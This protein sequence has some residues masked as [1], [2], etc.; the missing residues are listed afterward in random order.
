MT[1]EKMRHAADILALLA[2]QRIT[3]SVQGDA[4]RCHAPKGTL[5]PA[6]RAMLQEHKA[7]LLDF[8]RAQKAAS[9]VR[10]Q[11]VRTTGQESLPAPLSFA[12]QRLWFLDQ[13]QP[14]STTYNITLAVRLVGTL[15]VSVLEQSLNEVVRRH[16]SLR[17][18]FAVAEGQPVQV[19]ATL[20]PAGSAPLGGLAI[21]SLEAVPVQE[22]ERHVQQ[23]VSQEAE[24]PFNLVQ[25]P[26]MRA[27]L[28][29]L[30][31]AE[32]VLQLTIHHIIA[33]GWSINILV[34][35]LILLY[36]AYIKGQ[37]SP[38]PELPIQYADYARFQRAWLQGEV[39]Q[40][41]LAYWKALLAG[42]PALLELPLDY[43][44]P[45]VQTF[46]GATHPVSLPSPLTQ[47]LR[48]LSQRES[49]TLFMTLLA[50]FNVLLSRY[51]RQE[52]IVVGTP[53]ANRTHAETEGLIG[54]FVNMLALRTD[55]TGNPS[56]HDLLRRVRDVTQ[57]AYSHQ[58]VPFEQVVEALQPERDL[59]YTPLFQVVLTLQKISLGKVEFDNVSLHPLV[60][61]SK[62]SQFDLV[63]HLEESSTVIEGMFEYNTDL[64]E[65]ATIARM[66]DHWLTL[67]QGIVADPTQRISDLR[68]L[69]E[70][71]RQCILGDWNATEAAYPQ[72]SC[73]HELF[74]AQVERSPDAIAVVWEDLQITYRELNTR[75]NRLASHLQQLGVGPE[76][77]VCLCME[78]SLDLVVGL[79]GILKAGGAYVPLDPTY[80]KERLAF[81]VEDTQARVLLTQQHLAERIFDAAPVFRCSKVVC[82]DTLQIMTPL[83][84][85]ED[86]STKPR[87]HPEHLVYVIYTSGS[88]GRPKG[89]AV[90][91]RNLTNLVSWHCR[92]FQLLPSDRTT[93]LAGIG[94]DA[95]AWEIWPSLLAGASLHLPTEAVRM[96]PEKLRDWLVT[97]GITVTFLPTPMAEQML[98]LAWPS[99]ISLRTILTGGDRLHHAPP[100]GLPF[101]LVNN[102]GPT[103]NTV[104][105]TSGVIAPQA[106]SGSAHSSP[107][108]TIGRPIANTK[109]Y[110]L[111]PQQRLVPIGVP[112][113]LCIG[114]AGIARGYLHRPELTAERFIQDPLGPDPGARLYRT[115]DL[116]RYRS[117][118]TIEFLGRLDQ[119]V[120]IRGFRI[121]LGEIETQ[122]SQHPVI[123]EAAVLAHA[124]ASG[125]KRLVAYVV[126]HEDA[127]APGSPDLRRYLQ[128]HLPDY[129]IPSDFIALSALPLTPN[130]KLDPRALPAPHQLRQ[131]PGEA[132]VAPRDSWELEMTNLWETVLGKHP[133]GV[134][135]D[136]FALGG[137]SLLA[138]ALMTQVQTLFGQ[139]LPLTALF[140]E[141]TIEHLARLLREHALEK[142]GVPERTA[143]VTRDWSPL[144]PIQPQGT[145]HP[146]FCVHGADGTVLG[147]RALARHLGRERPFYGLQARGVD[148]AQEPLTDIPVMASLYLQ[149][150]R[151][152]QPEGPYL[153]GGW[154]IGGLVAFEMAQQLVTQGQQVALV[155]L[156]DTW[157]AIDI[158]N[159]EASSP[160][161]Q[162]FLPDDPVFLTEMIR[163]LA[164]GDLSELS[165]LQLSSEQIEGIQRTIRL[166]PDSSPEQIHRLLRLYQINRQASYQYVPHPY[167]GQVLLFACEE[168]PTSSLSSWATVVPKGLSI[169]QT[170]GSHYSML[171]EPHVK[172]LAEHLRLWLSLRI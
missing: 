137:H 128:I 52:D 160:E 32:Y 19:I 76:T 118:G 36:Q 123:R 134:Q 5:T 113:E 96:N 119:Q 158:E 62:I 33:D 91:H 164:Q 144:V 69:S 58:D 17:T 116:A 31:Q 141:A 131:L 40:A 3:L 86:I 95:S 78:R 156:F 170:T 6:L 16:E 171:S 46:Q 1:P 87:P 99:S 167:S 41:Q 13:L 124:D 45:A 80:P 108:P 111:D 39:L 135:D 14:G 28:F 10:P 143:I 94:F 81:M 136:F 34:Q 84:K 65:A 107:V 153:L 63:L 105:A 142:A 51:S 29:L 20:S 157:L 132:F 15:H 49:V 35:E 106:A 4:L 101:T 25:G 70:V 130:G 82:L 125:D 12:Q 138:V 89:V 120:K 61:E 112:G 129:M 50:V 47:A 121:E 21:H 55:L 147:Y 159:M 64:F 110:I 100:V 9:M 27:T 93:Q 151:E 60:V 30:N 53:V 44:R 155:V 26:L 148:E 140:Q 38:L 115:G 104:V 98:A 73:I 92:A 23:L 133:I 8:L 154:S 152:L 79:L 127:P 163:K 117:D 77:L 54:L 172:K 11:L 122:L 126:F 97:E 103:E 90:S 149:A 85:A 139:N 168:R 56:F 146:F 43:P 42:A 162:L 150:V 48:E 71:E 57:A 109:I 22:R 72:E 18:T 145:Q 166:F 88:T 37:S 169:Q 24:R 66:A 114:G 102:Y 165:A 67:L 74:E 59:S 2:G 83:E 75:A 68:L 161:K 7:E